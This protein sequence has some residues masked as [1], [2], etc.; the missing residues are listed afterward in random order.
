LDPLDTSVAGGPTQ[1]K[2]LNVRGILNLLRLHGPCSR[3]DLVRRSGLRAPTVSSAIRHLDESGLIEFLGPAE[4]KGGRR[5]IKL[6]FNA[7]AGH[8]IGIDVG[9]T[10][11]R[12]ALANLDGAIIGRWACALKTDEKQPETVCSIV[13]NAIG[14]LLGENELTRE[15]LLAIAVGVPGITDSESGR[16]VAAPNLNDWQDVPVRE[17]LYR[18]FKLP[19]AVENDVNLAAVGEHWKGTTTQ[20][21]NFVFIAIGTGIGAGIFVNGRL[22]RG[23]SS[24]AGEIGYLQV[25]GTPDSPIAVH[26]TG[27]LEDKV[28]GKAIEHSWRAEGGDADMRATDVLDA[29][30]AGDQTA[31]KIL[32]DTALILSHAISNVALIL[33][34]STVVIGGGIGFSKPLFQRI[35]Q[36]VQQN[37][38]ARPR[39][40]QSTLGA[41]AQMFG[42]IYMALELADEEL[43]QRIVHRDRGSG[44]HADLHVAQ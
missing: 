5:A 6:R 19:I 2:L 38:V 27:Q 43:T 34:P 31:H 12:V 26:H 3:A 28:S 21:N 24:E 22:Y 41:N 20:E 16:I 7:R 39:L 44:L 35:A 10:L 25:P 4:S 42:A 14:H 13:K 40:L 17:L 15:N 8:V 23:S 32:E 36:L 18:H 29:A 9:G 37:E 33:N 1:L 11:L 30:S